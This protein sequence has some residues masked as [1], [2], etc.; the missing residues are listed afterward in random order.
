MTL[1]TSWVV[2]NLDGI[3]HIYIYLYL[4]ING[5]NQFPIIAGITKKNIVRKAWAVTIIDHPLT[6]TQGL[7]AVFHSSGHSNLYGFFPG[8]RV[9]IGVDWLCFQSLYIIAGKG[10]L[11]H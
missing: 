2:F 10:V 8:V 1:T 3:A 9:L 5:T 11:S 6:L 7:I 4:S